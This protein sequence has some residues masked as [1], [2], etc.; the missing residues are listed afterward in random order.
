MFLAEPP[1][2]PY[3]FSFSVLGIPVRVHP[4]F[5]VAGAVLGMG[6]SNGFI[7][8]IWVAALF[9]SI[10]IHEL[11]HALMM[12]RFGETP[13]IVLYM[14]GGLAIADSNAW[15]IG[16]SKA[17]RSSAKQIM[18]SAAGPA[19][20][21]M[22][23]ALILLLIEARGGVVEFSGASFPVFWNVA[24][25]QPVT[26]DTLY[27]YA[28]VQSLLYINIFWGLVNLLPVYP[29]DG[30]Q[31]S[32]ELCMAQFPDGVV[33]SLWIS[34]GVGAA[35]AFYGLTRMQSIF[36]ALMFG[37]LAYSSYQTLQQ[38]SGRGGFRGGPWGGGRRPW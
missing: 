38:Y 21:F 34:V 27:W 36:I 17:A 26:S 9:V 30:G 2:T 24:L 1:R 7:M 25:A 14:M 12:R 33:K 6:D 11:G 4:F 5:W 37:M 32:R 31:I 15:N 8:V 35:V 3:D 10:L 28:L 16:S 19:A 13:R 29:L 23:A 22:F 18:I 20:G